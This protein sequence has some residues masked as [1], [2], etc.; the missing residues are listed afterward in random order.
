MVMRRSKHA[1]KHAV[2]KG[3]YIFP[4]FTGIDF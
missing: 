3:P 1:E 4:L 2:L